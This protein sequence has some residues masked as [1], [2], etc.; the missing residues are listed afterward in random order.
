M[1][2]GF[3]KINVSEVKKKVNNIIGFAQ[4]RKV[5]NLIVI[6]LFLF[7]LVWGSWIRLQNLPLLKDATT[8]EY[9]PLALDPYYFL[10]LAETINEQGSLPA[11][12]VMRHSAIQTGFTDEILPQVVVLLHK[13][14][15]FFGEYS[16]Q[17]VH[18]LY[19]VIFFVLGLITFFFLIYV[20]T[21]SKL[22]ALISSAFLSVIPLYLHRTQAGFADHDSIGIFAFFLTLLVY[23]LALKYLDKNET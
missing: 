20:L 13:I 2:E 8:G 3:V 17:Y 1:D 22:I 5:I 15:N 10:R 6:I 16:L 7:L 19:P 9:I 14:S 11:F 4:Q 23:S 12:D 21:N 18:V